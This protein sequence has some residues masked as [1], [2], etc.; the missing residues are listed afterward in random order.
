MAKTPLLPI[1]LNVNADE[2]QKWVA[3]NMAL[4]KIKKEFHNPDVHRMKK[5]M[6]GYLKCQCPE[7][8]AFLDS[9][10]YTTKQVILN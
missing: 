1:V 8:S 7:C 4:L 2:V 5:A 6:A 10:C 9:V 3:D